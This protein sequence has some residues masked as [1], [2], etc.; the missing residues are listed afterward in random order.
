MCESGA[1]FF[2]TVQ[3]RGFEVEGLI[4]NN[5][6][7]GVTFKMTYTVEKDKKIFLKYKEMQNGIG[8]KVIY[9]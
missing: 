3:Q 9:D 4:L 1:T 7:G 6:L 5:L 2:C 8:R